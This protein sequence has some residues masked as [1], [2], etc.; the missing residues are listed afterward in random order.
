MLAAAGVLLFLE[1]EE[2]LELAVV[3]LERVA[4]LRQLMEQPIQAAAV[5]QVKIQMEI[6]QV[7]QAAPVLL[8]LS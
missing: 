2:L 7:G 1:V 4:Q 3:E 8:F 6:L 5:V